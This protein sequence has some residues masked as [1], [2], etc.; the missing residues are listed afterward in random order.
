MILGRLSDILKAPWV[1]MTTSKRIVA[2]TASGRAEDLRYLAELARS[3]EFKPVIDRRYF[4]D[5]LGRRER[6][7]PK[8]PFVPKTAHVFSGQRQPFH[9]RHHQP[10]ALH[11]LRMR[12]AQDSVQ[13][14]LCAVTATNYATIAEARE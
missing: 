7:Q 8:E 2:G 11:T 5:F 6:I 3:G 1:S 4:L 12:R 9:G 13:E 10:P 14:T